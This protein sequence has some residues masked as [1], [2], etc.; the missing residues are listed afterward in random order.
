MGRLIRMAGNNLDNLHN[1]IEEYIALDDDRVK[2]GADYLRGK[3]DRIPP[4]L[5]EANNELIDKIKTNLKKITTV[6]LY[7]EYK[8]LKT[9]HKKSGVE[10]FVLD[11]LVK[12]LNWSFEKNGPFDPFFHEWVSAHKESYN[13]GSRKGSYRRKR[14]NKS[15]RIK[16]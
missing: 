13:G 6:A 15:R 10:V 9:K 11:E 2:A 8:F 1:L 16:R 4:N 7:N 5:L 3:I 12:K 14:S